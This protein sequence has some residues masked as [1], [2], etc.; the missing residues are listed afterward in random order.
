M[1]LL[2]FFKD[3]SISPLSSGCKTNWLKFSRNSDPFSNFC[4]IVDT[5]K[6]K[7]VCHKPTQTLSSFSI[8]FSLEDS[9][10]IFSILSMQIRPL[11]VASC[12]TQS[13]VYLIIIYVHCFPLQTYSSITV[14]AFI[15]N[16]VRA[17]NEIVSGV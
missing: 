14:N 11:P 1:R 5:T 17:I 13:V 4:A 6:L 8:V 9:R 12:L 3:G 15:Q 16:G 7:L 10:C 2:I